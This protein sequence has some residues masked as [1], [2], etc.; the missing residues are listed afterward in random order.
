M[1]TIIYAIPPLVR[2]TEHGIRDGAETTVEAA[3]SHGR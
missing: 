3:G 1:L 2:I